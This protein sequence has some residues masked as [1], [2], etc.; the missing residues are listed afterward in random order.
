[1]DFFFNYSVNIELMNGF[2]DGYFLWLDIRLR[3]DF[4]A[5]YSY[6]CLVRD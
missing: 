3:Y 4:I 6:I 5:F 2:K 1:M